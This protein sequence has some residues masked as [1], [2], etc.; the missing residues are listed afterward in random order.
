LYQQKATESLSGQ[1][2]ATDTKATGQNLAADT[3]ATE[4][5]YLDRT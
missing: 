5:V 3:K 4:R 2:L 1:N